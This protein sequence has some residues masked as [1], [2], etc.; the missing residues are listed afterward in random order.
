[1][2]TRLPKSK[3]AA[4]E[5]SITRYTR[6]D[7][8]PSQQTIPGARDTKERQEQ[9][10]RSLSILGTVIDVF[11]SCYL[12]SSE[13]R[14]VIDGRQADT[15]VRVIIIEVIGVSVRRAEI[16]TEKDCQCYVIDNQS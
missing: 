16:T 15:E 11:A 8:T 5:C 6:G 3:L 4:K 7:P 10:I 9:T 12:K 1:M 14:E 13:E 2:A